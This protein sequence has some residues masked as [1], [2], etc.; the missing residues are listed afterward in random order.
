MENNLFISRNG[1]FFTGGEYK[2]KLEKVFGTN[3]AKIT[4][5]Q[6]PEAFQAPYATIYHAEGYKEGEYVKVK[7]THIFNNG[8]MIAD[9]VESF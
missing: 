8:S 5:P 6:S 4:F 9:V 2:G 1:N 7:I 3:D